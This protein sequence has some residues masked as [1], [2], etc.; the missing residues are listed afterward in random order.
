MKIPTFIDLFAG[1]GGLSLG[2]M[3]A[4]WKGIFAVEKSKDAFQTLSHNLCGEDSKFKFHWPD[5]LPCKPKSIW[6]ILNNYSS[7]LKQL[8]GK[9]DLIA[10]GPPCQGFSSIGR[11]N[12]KDHR[13]RMT[14]EYIRMVNIIK[15]RFLLLEN[16]RGF[17]MAFK[18]GRK[19][20]SYHV[21]KRLENLGWG[22]YQVYSQ[23]IEAS[24]FGVPQ[25]RPRFIMIAVRKDLGILTENPFETIQNCIPKFRK[26]R[27]LNG[28]PTTVFEAI[29]DLEIGDK[30]LKDSLESK[31]FKEINYRQPK[32]S[33][34]QKLMRREVRKGYSPNSLRLPNHR[35]EIKKR[36]EEILNLCPKGRPLSDDFRKY[37]EMKKQC[38]IPLHPNQLGRT[39][40]T[41]PDDTL[42]YKEPRILTVREN[43]RLQSFPDWFD[44]KGKYTTGGDRRVKECPRYTQ[45][46]NAVPPLMGE[47]LGIALLRLAKNYGYE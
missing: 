24:E 30:T 19:P 3:Q 13:N 26:E 22:G 14:S 32:L 17:Q 41:L 2:L 5:W 28:H 31:G 35:P 15:P 45:V 36:F 20:F 40:T 23:M 46:G 34:Y 9:I 44:F 37:F 43:A 29:G 38:L 1:C 27:K 11:R 18:G 6:Q 47:G 25:S 33:P 7:N 16:V 10:G 4:G 21:R 8:E 42:H 39:V 12:P